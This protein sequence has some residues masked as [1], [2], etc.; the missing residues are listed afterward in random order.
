[1]RKHD[2]S[3]FPFYPRDFASD[4]NVEAM[5]TL[6]VGAYILLLCKA[7]HENPPASIPNDDAVLARWARLTPEEWSKVR[8]SVLAAW[9]TSED[10]RLIQPR[11]LAEYEDAVLHST[12]RSDAGRTNVRQRWEKDTNGIPIVCESNT[13]R[14][15]KPYS[16]D[17]S[18]SVPVAVSGS[19]GLQGGWSEREVAGIAAAY[20]AHRRSRSE[21][22]KGVIQ[23]ALTRIARSD[24]PGASDPVRWLLGRVM[25]YADSPQGKPGGYTLAAVNWFAGGCY[26]DADETWQVVDS[27]AV[28]P[29]R[30]LT[31]EQV[32]AKARRA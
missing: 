20:P 9:T 13:N 8:D 31:P 17:V 11:L 7:W 18:V 30:G 3:W 28:A 14:I 2:L 27:R 4:G 25:A 29:D 32:L 5:H 6:A 22:L 12:R 21:A 19:G 24:G 15:P 10:G 16:R 1:M 23:A 26:N